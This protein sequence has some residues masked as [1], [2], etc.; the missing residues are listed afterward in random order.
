M[1]FVFSEQTRLWQADPG[2]TDTWTDNGPPLHSALLHDAPR[3]LNNLASYC[4][5]CFQFVAS[6]SINGVGAIVVQ[7]QWWLQDTVNQ[8]TTGYAFLG[9]FPVL[10]PIG[11][12]RLCFTL[13]IQTDNITPPPG[14]VESA[15]SVTLT[16]VRLY[17]SASPIQAVDTGPSVAHV[18]AYPN[19]ESYT[20]SDASFRGAFVSAELAAAPLT[21]ALAGSITYNFYQVAGTGWVNWYNSS[22]TWDPTGEGALCSW[23]TIAVPFTGAVQYDRIRT[24]EFSIWG[25]WE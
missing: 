14:S 17:L 10:L 18:P 7:P 3:V 16:G 9:C 2:G 24:R 6:A 20:I 13:G 12:K 22:A 23:C 11:A 5:P 15:P 1:A 8:P 4:E 19:L 25:V 21:T